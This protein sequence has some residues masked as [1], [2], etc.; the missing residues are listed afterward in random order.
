MSRDP[1][2]T[3]VYGELGVGKT[4]DVLAAFPE[5]VFVAAPGALAPCREL[6][7][8]EPPERHDLA[9]F[10][11]VEKF[12]ASLDNRHVALCIDDATLLADRTAAVA[13]KAGL[14]GYDVW[15]YVLLS[16]MRMRDTLRRRGFHVAFT[17]HPRAAH[18]ENGVRFKGGPSFQGQCAQKI[19]AASDFLLRAETRGGA[20]HS[21]LLGGPEPFGWNQV[22]RCGWSPDWIQ[23]SRYNTPD[24]SPMNLGEILRLAGFSIPRMRGLEWQEPI[25]SALANRL[26]E[27]PGLS[28][29]EHVR[30]ALLRVRDFVLSK[31]SNNSAY[32][33]WTVRDG[34]DRA[35][36][37]VA[38]AA[39]RQ[40]LW[41]KP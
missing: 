10:D 6:W 18:V 41:G 33:Y 35:V 32:A 37:H 40:A 3:I 5:G 29:P 7:G 19:P 21:D 17:C 8:F 9:S 4:A 36:L 1:S 15:G 24:Y 26:L 23:R 39:G 2:F 11:E 16:A 30:S 34:H 31:T 13:V 27:A 20:A 22:Y 12:A 14:T 28:D 38:R 25:V